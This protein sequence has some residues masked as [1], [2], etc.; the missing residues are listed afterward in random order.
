MGGSDFLSSQNS[1]KLLFEMESEILN[2]E[3]RK[4][5]FKLLK[6]FTSWETKNIKFAV[7]CLI[8]L[9]PLNNIRVIIEVITPNS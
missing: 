8:F 1:Q 5:T 2:W 3:S 7:A 9:K 6:M 4:L